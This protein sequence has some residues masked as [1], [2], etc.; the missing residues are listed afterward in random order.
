MA[1]GPCL[2]P[3]T[4]S[5]FW[6]QPR[7]RHTRLEELPRKEAIEKGVC[8]VGVGGKKEAASTNSSPHLSSPSSLPPVGC[9]ATALKDA[10]DHASF[11]SVLSARPPLHLHS[12]CSYQANSEAQPLL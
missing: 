5:L 7:L 8:G 4:Q 10:S 9:H 1:S 12:F 11:T 2:Y 3:S 6:G